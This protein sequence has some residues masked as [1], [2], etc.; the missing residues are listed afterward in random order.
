MN[1]HDEREYRNAMEDEQNLNYDSCDW[2]GKP[3][4]D[5]RGIVYAGDLFCTIKCVSESGSIEDKEVGK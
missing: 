5:G 3:L 1:R 4:P 2:C